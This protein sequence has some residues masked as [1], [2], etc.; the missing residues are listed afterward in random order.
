MA[1]YLF[2]ACED[3]VVP[4]LNYAIYHKDIRSRD[5][6]AHCI[7]CRGLRWSQGWSGCY[8]IEKNMLS[9]LGT[10]PWMSSLYPIT[11]PVEL[12]QALKMQ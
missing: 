10:E 6:I 12:P 7:L 3:K 2:G 5:A 8:G 11:I 4:K 1:A 9:L